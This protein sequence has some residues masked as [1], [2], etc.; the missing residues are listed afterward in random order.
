MPL[1]ARALAAL[2]L[3]PLLAG[4]SLAGEAWVDAET[5]AY[6]VT[7]SG[8]GV[9]DGNLLDMCTGHSWYVPGAEVHDLRTEDRKTSCRLVGEMPLDDSNPL[10]MF[11]VTADHVFGRVTLSQGSGVGPLTLEGLDLTVHFPG[12]VLVASAGGQVSGLTVT[13][14]DGD[15]AVAEGLVATASRAQGLAPWLLPAIGG[16]VVGAAAVGG[17]ALWRRR[18]RPANEVSHA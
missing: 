14:T 3:V 10:G 11:V 13:W 4:C 7:V 2:A 15:R 1:P 6:A 16:T 12:D 8:L 9:E 17:V 5:I 18:A